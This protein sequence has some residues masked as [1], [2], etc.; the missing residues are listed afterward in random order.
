MIVGAFVVGMPMAIAIIGSAHK[1]AR[2]VR[3]AAAEFG[4]ADEVRR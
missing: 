4:I 3:E 2:P 1:T